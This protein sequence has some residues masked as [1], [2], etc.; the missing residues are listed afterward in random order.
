MK[1]LVF[2][3]RKYTALDTL[4]PIL[5]ALKRRWPRWD[6]RLYRCFGP[7]ATFLQDRFFAPF[8][9]EM[10]LPVL[11][12][13]PRPPDGDSLARPS[14]DYTPLTARLLAEQGPDLILID[15]R[16]R[17]HAHPAFTAIADFVR[18]TGTPLVIRHHGLWQWPPAV[19]VFPHLP[20]LN[21]QYWCSSPDFMLPRKQLGSRRVECPGSPGWDSVWLEFLARRNP[22]PQ[23]RRPACLFLV[24]KI[25]PPEVPLARDFGDITFAEFRR[26]T[27]QLLV[28]SGLAQEMDI[29]VKPYPTMD[30]ALL[31]QA[32]EAAGLREYRLHYSSVYS[33]IGRIDLQV[34][35]LTGAFPVP[36]LAQV[37]SLMLGFSIHQLTWRLHPRETERLR[38]AWC[39][40]L[41]RPGDIKGMLA[42][43][44]TPR[45]D[46]RP[47]C[48]ERMKRSIAF[49]REI[50]PDR[51]GERCCRLIEE[52]LQKR[53]K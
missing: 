29:I 3:W 1:I 16:V 48:R 24:R 12:L 33:L 27:R 49:F 38:P 39:H 30:R 32:L 4:A 37:P 8:L 20:G 21:Y 10:G 40:L 50:F 17:A 41:R 43:I 22:S 35:E 46:L 44:F 52:L 14:P 2:I 25:L 23:A 42:Q 13:A 34:G 53:S 15:D 9:A 28:E 47:E 31:V 11:P 45:G 51:A 26:S 6:I 18:D 5:W 19:K 7:R 36:F